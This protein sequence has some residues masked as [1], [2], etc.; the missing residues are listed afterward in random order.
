MKILL[1]DNDIFYEQENKLCIYKTT[2]EFAIELIKSGNQVELLQTKMKLN[3]KFH[4]FN[5]LNTELLVTAIKRNR[6]K[7]LTYVKAYIFGIYK[8]YKSD[9]LYLYY[10]TNYEYLAFFAKVLSKPYGLN[11]R[12]ERGIQSKKSFL[13]YKYSKV[14]F[15]VSPFFTKIVKNE[16]ANA[17]TQKPSIVFDNRDMIYERAFEKK[18]EYKILF[19]GRLDI[20][21]GIYELIYGVNEI[22]SLGYK[23]KLHIVGDG[24]EFDKL[25]DLVNKLKI[26]EYVIFE[27]ATTEK[28]KISEFYKSSDIFILPSYHEGFPRTLY[29]AMIFG[30]PIITTFVGGISFL[31][32]NEYNCFEIQ[33]KSI[34]SIVSKLK[35]VL[36]NYELIENIT[37]NGKNTVSEIVD[38]R[39]PTHAWELNN[40]LVNN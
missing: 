27:G 5:V 23:I 26:S 14:V 18:V 8:L 31:M 6:F 33:P 15:T 3:S 20:E 1:I 4:D 30:L 39:R 10:P 7:I 2:G 24:S 36:E 37:I 19:L 40:F 25:F 38:Y 28:I 13:L 35:Y 21:K 17:F 16:C 11:V 29:E 32:K 12:G 34:S 9:F 22:L